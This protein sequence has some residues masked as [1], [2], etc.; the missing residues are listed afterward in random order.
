[1]AEKQTDQKRPEALDL[2]KIVGAL[3]G[4]SAVVVF[5]AAV[6]GSVYGSSFLSRLGFPRAIYSTSS[7]A[8]M[9]SIHTDSLSVLFVAA[10]AIGFVF[11]V[12]TS[13]LSH[14][15]AGSRAIVT[16]SVLWILGI[17]TATVVTKIRHEFSVVALFCPFLIGVAYYSMRPTL[18]RVTLMV[19]VFLNALTVFYWDVQRL[20]INDA[21]YLRIM[22][23]KA[24]WRVLRE[25]TET[26]DQTYPPIQLMAKENIPFLNEGEKVDNVY[27][28]GPRPDKFILLVAEDDRQYFLIERT[29]SEVIPVIVQKDEVVSLKFINRGVLPSGRACV[30]VRERL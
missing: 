21:D 10:A 15:M 23:P 7:T 18:I 28:Y 25:G 1:M 16:L 4:V 30:G 8:Q 20:G 9:F 29:E 6:S 26:P 22:K 27:L 17:G 12:V 13:K 11:M 24:V 14:L 19:I 2:I 3:G 5:I